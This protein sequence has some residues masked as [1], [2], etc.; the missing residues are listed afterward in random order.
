VSVL[1]LFLLVFAP[2]ATAFANSDDFKNG[3]NA[4]SNGRYA[5]A[6]L[7]LGRAYEELQRADPPRQM[8]ADA[9]AIALVTA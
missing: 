3:T 4:L 1:R 7:L 9:A 5:E 6:A 2:A 8:D